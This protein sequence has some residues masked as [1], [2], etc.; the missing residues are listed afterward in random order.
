M[1]GCANSRTSISSGLS[2]RIRSKLCIRRRMRCR[3]RIRA[4]VSAG[5]NKRVRIRTSIRTRMR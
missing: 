2:T 3:I 4:S 1:G 5:I